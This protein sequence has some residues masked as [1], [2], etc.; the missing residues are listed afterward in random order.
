MTGSVLKMEAVGFTGGWNVVCERMKR[1]RGG[2]QKLD[3]RN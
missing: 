2:S 1:S 3:L